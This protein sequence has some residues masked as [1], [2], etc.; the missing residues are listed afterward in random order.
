MI[1][2]KYAA[3]ADKLFRVNV[4]MHGKRNIHH[5][6][7][8]VDTGSDHTFINSGVEDYLDILNL[9]EGDIDVVGGGKAKTIETKIPKIYLIPSDYRR[10]TIKHNVDA[11][12]IDNLEEHLVLGANFFKEA[13]R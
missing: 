12:I 6:T 7:A 11:S 4:I 1:R 5:V 3:D 10:H 13:V 9:R 8:L 2:F